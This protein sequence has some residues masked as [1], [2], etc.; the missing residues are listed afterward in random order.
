MAKLYFY[1]SAM[2]AGKTTTLL[3]ASYNY[4]ERAMNTVIFSPY[5]DTRFS[6]E[7]VVSRIGIESE[8][9]VFDD[10]FDFVR[11]VDAYNRFKDEPLHCMLI[12]ECNLLSHEQV[13]Q[14]CHIVDF[15]DIPILCYGLRTNY[16]GKCFEGSQALLGLADELIELKAICHCGKKASMNLR[17][18][19]D[20]NVIDE[21]K[22]VVIGGNDKYVSVCRK[23]FFLKDTGKFVK[24]KNEPAVN[25]LNLDE[26][27]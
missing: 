10:E 26:Q 25:Y 2:N 5:L 7:K 24:P 13:L 18:D 4:R 15:H 16:M 1:Y 19:E 23:H 12:D 11:Y 6:R 20:G 21:G 14:L 22:E 3:Q 8:A 27:L 17:V 9:V